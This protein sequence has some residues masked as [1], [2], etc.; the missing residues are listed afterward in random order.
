MVQ[1]TLQS[2][3]GRYQSA[4]QAGMPADMHG[5]DADSGI[6]ESASIGFGLAVS[7]GVADNGV[8]LGGPT[9]KGIAVRD[10]TISHDTPDRYEEPDTVTVMNRGDIWVQVASAVVNDKQAYYNSS[11]G[12]LGASGIS[13]AVAIAGAIFLDTADEDGFS[14]VRLSNGIGDITT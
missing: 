14:R 4:A 12:E 6:C 8:I 3:Y 9:F 11:T 1:N 7:R 13:N 2:S 10:V 5:W